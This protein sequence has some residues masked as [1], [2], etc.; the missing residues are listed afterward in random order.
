[1]RTPLGASLGS[2][3]VAHLRLPPDLPSRAR[4]GY[5][6]GKDLVLQIDALVSSVSGSLRWGPGSDFH[7]LSVVHASR[8][9]R[10]PASRPVFHTPPI[11]LL[12]VEPADTVSPA[13]SRARLR[14]PASRPVFHVPSFRFRKQGQ[15]HQVTRSASL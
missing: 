11:H 15:R 14:S 10:S 13:P 6:L 5:A 7:L 3:H 8:T 12:K 1:M 9:L 2:G 4:Q